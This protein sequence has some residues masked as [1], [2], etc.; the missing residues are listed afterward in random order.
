[1]VGGAPVVVKGEIK[2][3]WNMEMYPMLAKG[4]DC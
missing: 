2:L 4:T 3:N 1:M